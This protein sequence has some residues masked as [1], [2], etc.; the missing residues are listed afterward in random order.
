M[1]KGPMTD[2]LGRALSFGSN[3][4]VKVQLYKPGSTQLLKPMNFWPAE[5]G[6]PS[7]DAKL[8]VQSRKVLQKHRPQTLPSLMPAPFTKRDKVLSSMIKKQHPHAVGGGC[9]CSGWS[10]EQGVGGW[11]ANW[12]TPATLGGLAAVSTRNGCNPF[13]YHTFF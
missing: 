12:G 11:C 3:G 6:L 13:I 2:M 7:Y 8:V 4:M 5:L 1:K 10:D 9:R